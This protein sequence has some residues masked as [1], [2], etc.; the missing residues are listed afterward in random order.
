MILHFFTIYVY[1]PQF[2]SFE[3]II[4]SHNNTSF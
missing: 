3:I 4:A 2:F 1:V